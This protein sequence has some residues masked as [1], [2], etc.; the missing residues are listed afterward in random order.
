MPFINNWKRCK[1]CQV[2]CY[3]G[4]GGGVCWKTK[5][6]HEFDDTKN[7]FLVHDDP[8]APEDHNWRFCTG[9]HEL[10]YA[11]SDDPGKCKCPTGQKHQHTLLSHEYTVG[12]ADSG[13]KWCTKCQAMCYT[14]GEDGS[15]PGDDGTGKHTFD[16]APHHSEAR[17]AGYHLFYTGE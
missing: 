12:K 10:Y 3:A 7:Y 17:P 8:G 9:C 4:G 15:C 11:G 13:W 6:A 16:A 1:N 5:G 2:L 14:A